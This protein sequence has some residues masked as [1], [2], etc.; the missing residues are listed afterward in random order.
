[1]NVP[2]VHREVVALLPRLRRYA[3]ALARS[4]DVADDLV[5]SACVRAFAG[6]GPGAGVP[7]DAWMLTIVRNLWFDRLRRGRTEATV[8]DADAVLQA[9]ASEGSAAQSEAR[10]E[11][12]RVRAAI[13]RLPDEQR[14]VLLLVCV[15]ELSYKDAAAALDVPIGTVMSRLARARLRLAQWMGEGGTERRQ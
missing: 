12:G 9:T 10:V 3:A 2:E 6:S 14:E 15:E 4:N 13:D 7:V 8:D 5:Q 11:L 1:M